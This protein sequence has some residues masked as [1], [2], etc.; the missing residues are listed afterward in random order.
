MNLYHF[1]SSV[2]YHNLLTSTRQV[3]LINIVENYD[4]L[5][6]FLLMVSSVIVMLFGVQRTSIFNSMSLCYALLRLS[7][8]LKLAVMVDKRMDEK[9]VY[10][11]LGVEK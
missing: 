2:V 8:S 9:V 6:L 11:F 4:T 3:N 1:K 7:S 5:I 10:F